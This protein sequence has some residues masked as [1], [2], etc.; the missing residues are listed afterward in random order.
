MRSLA[1]QSKQTRK[2]NQIATRLRYSKKYANSD[3][4]EAIIIGAFGELYT[5]MFA[6][7]RVIKRL[8]VECFK[9][10]LFCRWTTLSV[11][12]QKKKTFV[13]NVNSCERYYE[14]QDKF[15]S[16][17]PFVVFTFGEDKCGPLCEAIKASRTLR[18]VVRGTC[19][20]TQEDKMTKDLKAKREE[21]IQSTWNC[22]EAGQA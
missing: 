1:I 14:A 8:H 19:S 3:Q 16:H 12:L 7:V 2:A 4:R 9:T 6:L 22:M 13:R 15:F 5:D 17:L 20:C 18:R 10:I 11:R 21:V